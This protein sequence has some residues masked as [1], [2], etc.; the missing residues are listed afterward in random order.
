MTKVI[1]K[2]KESIKHTELESPAIELAPVQDNS[3]LPKVDGRTAQNILFFLQHDSLT[4]P[5]KLTG[6]HWQA[7][8]LMSAIIQ[9]DPPNPKVPGA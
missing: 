5:A 2:G 8:Q 6:P 4:V 3:V 9:L 1:S 7:C